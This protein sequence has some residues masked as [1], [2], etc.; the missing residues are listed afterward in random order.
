MLN[1]HRHD[2][3]S[4]PVWGLLYEYEAY[5]VDLARRDHVFAAAAGRPAARP[6]SRQ[7]IT[8]KSLG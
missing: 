8:W 5:D 6:G 7:R 3:R 1:L 2:S 4:L